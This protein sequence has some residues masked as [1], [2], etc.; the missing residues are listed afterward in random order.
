MEAW[1]EGGRGTGLAQSKALRSLG[2]GTPPVV[3]LRSP[4]VRP[5][6]PAVHRQMSAA[7]V[8]EARRRSSRRGAG[9]CANPLEP[10]QA[11]KSRRNR[12]LHIALARAILAVAP[13]TPGAFVA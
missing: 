12:G 11:Q 10:R 8:G 9:A 7:R 13:R 1:A 6:W 3:E 5:P 2:A 4:P